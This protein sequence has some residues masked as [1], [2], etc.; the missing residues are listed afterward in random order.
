MADFVK[1]TDF[2]EKLSKINNRVT[3]NKTRHIESEKK[4]NDHKTY[5]TKVTSDPLGEVKL[6]PTERL[7]IDLIN[8]YSFLNGGKYYFEEVSQNYLVFQP[9]LNYFKTYSDINNM[10]T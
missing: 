10:F 6:I 9:V 2:D 8:G 4:L 3:S 1:R 5:H 7:T